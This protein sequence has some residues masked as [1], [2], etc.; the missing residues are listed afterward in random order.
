MRTWLP[1]GPREE[2]AE[3]VCC[4]VTGELEFHVERG[5]GKRTTLLTKK[6]RQKNRNGHPKP[7]EWRP[8]VVN[9]LQACATS[10]EI[11]KARVCGC[12]APTPPGKEGPTGRN[13]TEE[14]VSFR[15]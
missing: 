12:S 15:K 3:Q 14:G 1:E 8:A 4:G 6:P 7:P 10:E 13:P 11:G 9:R 2:W 5:Q